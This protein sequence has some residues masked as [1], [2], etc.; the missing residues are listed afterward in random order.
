MHS[1]PLSVYPTGLV[2]ELSVA[3]IVYRTLPG[4]MCQFAMVRMCFGDMPAP[5]LSLLAIPSLLF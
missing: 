1:Q 2:G 5:F 4:M 3:I